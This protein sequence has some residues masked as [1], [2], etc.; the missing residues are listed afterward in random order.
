M[1]IGICCCA[2]R[3]LLG[4]TGASASDDFYRAGRRTFA[5]AECHRRAHL[6]ARPP[7]PSSSL[8]PLPLIG[9]SPCGDP[10]LYDTRRKEMSNSM[11]LVVRATHSRSLALRRSSSSMFSRFDASIARFKSSSS[12]LERLGGGR[13]ALYQSQVR[14]VRNCLRTSL[15]GKLTVEQAAAVWRIRHLRAPRSHL[16]PVNQT[17]QWNRACGPSWRPS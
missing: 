11:T 7:G 9:Q 10:P 2:K 14:H 5:V 4:T 13:D 16:H 6:Q 8:P 1:F 12:S 3:S 17:R 15:R